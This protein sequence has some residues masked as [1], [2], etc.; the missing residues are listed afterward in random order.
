MA[1]KLDPAEYRYIPDTTGTRA[2]LVRTVDDRA[3]P[4]EG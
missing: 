1:P 4:R 3:A 2:D